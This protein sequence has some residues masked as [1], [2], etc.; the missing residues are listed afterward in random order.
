METG[1]APSA[2]KWWVKLVGSMASVVGSSDFGPD[3]LIS[4]QTQA[5]TPEDNSVRDQILQ[6]PKVGG[7]VCRPF[8]GGV[9][10]LGQFDR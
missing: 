10:Y 5:A 7:V 6:D 3:C 2:S 1:K 8:L 9:K 4:P